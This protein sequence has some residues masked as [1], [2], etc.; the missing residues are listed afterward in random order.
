M[1]YLQISQIAIPQL[2][3]QTKKKVILPPG[4]TKRVTGLVFYEKIL[5]L[6]K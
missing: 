3:E 2:I 1:Q 4:Y 6:L 5:L